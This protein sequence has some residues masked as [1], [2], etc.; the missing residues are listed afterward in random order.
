MVKHF[1]DGQTLWS[2]SG[3]KWGGAVAHR[4]Q[5]RRRRRRRRAGGGAEERQ[6][7]AGALLR[8]RAHGHEYTHVVH[9][10]PN[11]YMHGQTCTQYLTAHTNEYKPAPA[12]QRRLA[13][14][15]QAGAL[16]RV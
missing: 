4:Q 2:N 9:N 14:R 8:A 7:Q 3:Q 15:R 6:Q 11:D 1:S 13:D 16:V 10:V 5:Q 12:P